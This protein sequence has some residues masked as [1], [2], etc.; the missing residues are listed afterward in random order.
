[1]KTIALRFGEHFSPECGTIAAHEE[2]IRSMGY[3]WYG[4]MGPKISEKMI[5][6]IMSIESPKILLIRS[7]KTERYWASVKAIQY[8]TPPKEG[9]PEYY[10]DNAGMF[11][12][13]IKINAFSLADRDVMS[14]C[15]VTSS[16]KTL[17][18]TSKHSM[19]PY[20]IINYDE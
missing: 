5:R 6:E 17:G 10:R 3:V 15:K 7:G 9:I 8:L 13:W 20:F 18:E 12:T 1:M 16:G 14:K 19:S 11:K 2:I 4:K